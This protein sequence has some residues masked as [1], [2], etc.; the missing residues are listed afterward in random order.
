[1]PPDSRSPFPAQL[2]VTLDG[3]SISLG[4]PV[5]VSAGSILKIGSGRAIPG[6]RTYLAIKGGLDVPD[7]LG[8]KSTFTLGQLA[9]MEV[10]R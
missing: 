2:P 5:K 10:E 4:G 6:V 1:M 3:E 9:A 7:Y 8:S